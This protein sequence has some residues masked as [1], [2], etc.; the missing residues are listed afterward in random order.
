MLESKIQSQIIKYLE[1]IGA[2]VVNVV[3]AGKPGTP[4]VLCC[5]EGFF[6]GIEVKRPGQKPRR[7][8][9]HHLERIR[10]AKGISMVATSAEDAKEQLLTLLGRS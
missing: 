5:V 6:V 4:D 7:L 2:Y 10:K 3:Q 9:E 8:Q 1:S